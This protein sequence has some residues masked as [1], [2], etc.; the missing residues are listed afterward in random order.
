MTTLTERRLSDAFAFGPIIAT[1]AEKLSLKTMLRW[2][3]VLAMVERLRCCRKPSS[4][5]SCW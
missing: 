5:S 3:E 1:F 2:S 4:L